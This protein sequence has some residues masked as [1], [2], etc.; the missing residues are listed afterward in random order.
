MEL[1]IKL[2]NDPQ[3][4][5]LQGHQD[6]RERGKQLAGSVGFTG[7]RELIER[8]MSETKN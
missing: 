2:I 3:T 6:N 1:G 7:K 8:I 4:P 5:L